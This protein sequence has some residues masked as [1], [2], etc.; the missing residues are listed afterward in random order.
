MTVCYNQL[1]FFLRILF[2]S[3][4]AG[5]ADDPRK[6]RE[7]YLAD[8]HRRNPVATLHFGSGHPLIPTVPTSRREVIKGAFSTRILFI[9]E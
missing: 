2:F 1:A 5:G 4:P 7:L 3:K 8:H 9:S 6:L